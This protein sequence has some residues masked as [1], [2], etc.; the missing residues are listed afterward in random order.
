MARIGLYRPDP[1]EI[2]SVPAEFGIQR[3]PGRSP[4]D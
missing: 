2:E 3:D 1:L 4:Y